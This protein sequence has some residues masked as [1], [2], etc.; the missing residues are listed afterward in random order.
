MEI[1]I[2]I[3]IYIGKKLE[4]FQGFGDHGRRSQE[5]EKPKLLVS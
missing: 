4:I 1:Y 3:Y 5:K 2:Y